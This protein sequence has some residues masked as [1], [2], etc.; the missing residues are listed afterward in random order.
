MSFDEFKKKILDKSIP[1]R[2]ILKMYLGYA[3]AGGDDI[4]EIIDLLE[5]H[6]PVVLDIL[7][8]EPKCK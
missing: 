4:E 7:S 5:E 2:Q 1:D 3:A 8:Q 6:R